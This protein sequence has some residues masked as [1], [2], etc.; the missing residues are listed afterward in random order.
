MPKWSSC[1]R[2]GI[3]LGPLPSHACNVY[4]IL[5]PTTGLFTPQYHFSFDY[6]FRLSFIRTGMLLFI[7]FGR[8][9]QVFRILHKANQVKLCTHWSPHMIPGSQ[10]NNDP[11]SSIVDAQTPYLQKLTHLMRLI[12]LQH[13]QM[14]ND[15]ADHD[16]ICSDP[17]WQNRN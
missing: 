12:L 9:Q 8:S 10:T 16:P 11:T 2:L 1:A 4:L 13:Q 15:S 6:S 17:S 14:I 7:P 5:N 3:N